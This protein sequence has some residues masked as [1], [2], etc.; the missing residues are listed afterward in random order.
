[1]TDRLQKVFLQIDRI[2]AEDKQ[3]EISDG[4]AYPK[5][6]IYGQRMSETLTLFEQSSETLQIAV[7]AQ[8]IKRWAIPRADYPMDRQGY[9]KWRTQL[10]IFHGDITAEIM[11][12]SGYNESEIKEVRDLLMKKNLKSNIN[13]QTLEDVACLV[14]L[15]YYIEDFISH[16]EEEMTIN[17]LRKTWSKM[18]ENA[19]V[20]ALKFEYS[21]EVSKL[22]GK[23]LNT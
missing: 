13:S 19:H 15:Q 6:L 8:H 22:I 2:N 3:I 17:I 11:E 14:F 10:K 18:S 9:L 7:R 4:Q 1:M 20:L 5:E 16:K 23:A 12:K 21:T